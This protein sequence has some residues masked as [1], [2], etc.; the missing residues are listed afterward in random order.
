LDPGVADVAHVRGGWKARKNASGLEL[1]PEHH[2][3]KS[4]FPDFPRAWPDFKPK[5]SLPPRWLPAARQQNL[6]ARTYSSEIGGL[7]TFLS[8]GSTTRQ[9]PAV[10]VLDVLPEALAVTVTVAGCCLRTGD[11]S[12][13]VSEA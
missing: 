8:V 4:F 6:S 1:L 3:S 11:L 9:R 7:T 5:G 12:Q 13:I 10:L 2:N